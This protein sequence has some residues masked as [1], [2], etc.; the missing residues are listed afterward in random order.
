MR[1]S[2]TL[3]SASMGRAMRGAPWMYDDG[4]ASSAI[5][6]SPASTTIHTSQ[7]FLEVQLEP[8]HAQ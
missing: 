6:T 4:E 2:P 8:G 5:H 3:L 1:L 7:R